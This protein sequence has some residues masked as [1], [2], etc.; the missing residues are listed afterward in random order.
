M[1]TNIEKLL[2]K[3]QK[4][5]NNVKNKRLSN[6]YNIDVLLK[7]IIALPKLFPI[8]KIS[9]ISHGVPLDFVF[10][11]DKFTKGKPYD[12][13][14]VH[15]TDQQKLAIEKYGVRAYL[16]G[17]IFMQY[18]KFKGWE[19]SKKASGTLAFPCHSTQ[20]LES[21]TDWDKYASE[22]KNLPPV[23]HPVKVCM[24]WKDLLKNKHIPFEKQGLEIVSAGHYYDPDFCKNLYNLLTTVNYT[25]SNEIGSY[26]F[27]SLDLEIP[28]FLY[29][30]KT[31]FIINDES[32]TPRNNPKFIKNIEIIENAF[33]INPHEHPVLINSE[34]KNVVKPYIII[35]QPQIN[36]YEFKKLLYTNLVFV[37]IKK[38]WF[39]VFKKIR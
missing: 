5:E 18:R 1:K 19:K 9:F 20:Y 13:Y 38:I 15:T 12:I 4:T 17:D 29:G 26:T 6:L 39:H 8:D 11:M 32:L 21:D 37:L 36:I 22:L 35:P 16:F 14:F 7:E 30:Q 34:H 33:R 27:Y 25:T 31:K 2:N 3:I 28:F 10:I 24:Y 23:Y